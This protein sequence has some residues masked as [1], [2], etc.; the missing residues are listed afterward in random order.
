MPPIEEFATEDTAL[1]FVWNG[2]DQYNEPTFEYPIE[3][4]VQW[5]EK[6][7]VM[8]GPGGTPI[9]VDVLVIALV[10]IILDS[11]MWLGTLDDW[12]GTGSNDT[13]STLYQVAA[14]AYTPDIKARE[15]RRRYGLIRYKGSL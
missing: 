6:T 4:D 15:T 10:D 8:S 1:L 7:A 12:I 2:E 13:D 9:T 5:V 3:I 11:V 14:A